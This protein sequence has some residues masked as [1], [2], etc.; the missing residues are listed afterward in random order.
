M[1][2]EHASIFDD[3]MHGLSLDAVDTKPEHPVVEC[4][5]IARLEIG[6]DGVVYDRHDLLRSRNVVRREREAVTPDELDRTL[7]ELR[8]RERECR[9]RFS[10]HPCRFDCNDKGADTHR[11]DC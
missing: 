11:T 10:R 2:R 1:V 7:R 6:C 3:G 8:E 4:N 5:D 9:P